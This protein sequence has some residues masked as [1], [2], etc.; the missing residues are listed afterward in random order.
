MA[1]SFSKPLSALAA[2]APQV[3]CLALPTALSINGPDIARCATAEHACHIL[4]TCRS[5]ITSC[6]YVFSLS[7]AQSLHALNQV[8]PL[9]LMPNEDATFGFW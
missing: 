8:S 2:A 1:D 9:K 4:Q 5:C 3:L 6:R 7:V